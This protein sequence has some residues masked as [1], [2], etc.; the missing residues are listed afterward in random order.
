MEAA[1]TAAADAEEDRTTARTLRSQADA[2]GN[3][4]SKDAQEILREVS[5]LG[6]RIK[7]AGDTL[8]RLAGELIE[9][10][11]KLSR[12]ERVLEETEG[13][14]EKAD[15]EREAAATAGGTASIP[16]SPGFGAR[17]S[18]RPGTSPPRWKTPGPRER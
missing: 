5:R 1:G 8:K 18:P 14:R 12:A 11:A 10:A 17:R 16:A 6:K 7:D 13:K 9:L 15:E 4:L 2:A 3:A